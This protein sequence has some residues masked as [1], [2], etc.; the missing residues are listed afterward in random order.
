MK[1]VDRQTVTTV[2]PS[3][4]SKMYKLYTSYK[5]LCDV[6]SVFLCAANPPR[7]T[8]HPQ[9]LKDVVPRESVAFSI[10]ATGTDPLSYQWQHK[11]EDEMWQPCNV[12]Q[13]PGANSSTLTICN[14]HKSDEGSYHCTVSNCAGSVTSQCATLTVGE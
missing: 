8:V 11:V 4:Y 9:V 1:T 2:K 6:Y 13:F 7:I 12:E 3:I 5:V 14:A 10:E